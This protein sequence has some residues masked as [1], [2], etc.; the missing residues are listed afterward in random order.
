[1]HFQTPLLFILLRIIFVFTFQKD[2]VVNQSSADISVVLCKIITNFLAKYI[3]DKQIFVSIIIP[4]SKNQHNHLKENVCS[5]LFYNAGLPAFDYN[6]VDRL[7]DNLYTRHSFNLILTD[8][9]ASI[10]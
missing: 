5:H 9:Y 8:D 3:S 7:V 10:L 6:I 4:P 2:L 1:M